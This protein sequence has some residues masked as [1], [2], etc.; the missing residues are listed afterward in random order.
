MGTGWSYFINVCQAVRVA[1]GAAWTV[2]GLIAVYLVITVGLPQLQSA[3]P[4]ASSPATSST[5]PVGTQTNPQ[6]AAPAVASP[7][8]SA[9]HGVSGVNPQ[10]GS[11]SAQQIQPPGSLPSMNSQQTNPQFAPAAPRSRPG[12]AGG[13]S[14]TQ[15][16]AQFKNPQFGH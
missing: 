6:F 7:R 15:P 5:T 3:L 8:G 4:A 11:P 13:S 14:F 2:V 10:F 16:N 12:A 9:P 1:I